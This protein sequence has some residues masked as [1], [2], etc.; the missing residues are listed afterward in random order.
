[1]GHFNLTLSLI[2]L[3]CCIS[4]YA[5]LHCGHIVL[6]PRWWLDRARARTRNWF[7]YLGSSPLLRD[8]TVL[9]AIVLSSARYR[10]A[11]FFPI[12]AM[13]IGGYGRWKWWWWF[14]DPC[15]EWRGWLG[16]EWHS[17][18]VKGLPTPGS[19][20]AF[21]LPFSERHW[22]AVLPMVC[23]HSRGAISCCSHMDFYA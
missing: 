5:C 7:V 19:L 16:F 17:L 22:F 18:W 2:V 20:L 9:H 23:F 12:F 3:L 15:F 11:R 6:I 1:M 8:V 10:G 21:S 14:C 4:C 13:Y